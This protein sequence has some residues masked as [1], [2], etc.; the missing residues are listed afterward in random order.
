MFSGGFD[1]LSPRGSYVAK[2]A[3][4][5]LV[6]ETY[7]LHPSGNSIARLQ[8]E[9]FF[10]GTYSIAITGG[11]FFRLKREKTFGSSWE[12]EGEGRLLRISRQGGRTFHISEDGEDIAKWSKPHLFGRYSI[13]AIDESDLNL[14]FCIFVAL[15]IGEDDSSLIPM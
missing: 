8:R 4:L 6:N 9:S 2:R 1:I 15:R 12:C 10:S 14:V 7:L 5:S 13:S 3:P 11:G